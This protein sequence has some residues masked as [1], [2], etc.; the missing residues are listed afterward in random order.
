MGTENHDE[1]TLPWDPARM[2]RRPS[3]GLAFQAAVLL[4]A[5]VSVSAATGFLRW[6]G[7]PE[8]VT[9]AAGGSGPPVVAST[10]PVS[11]EFHDWP[12]KTPDL[13][14][15]LTAQEYGYLQPCGCSKPQLGGLERRWNFL[16]SLKKR[17]WPVLALDLGDI[18]QKSGPQKLLKY[19]V[20]MQALQK[21]GYLAVSIG[22]NELESLF[23]ALGQFALNDEKKQ[24][25]VIC[26][27]LNNLDT[28]YKDMVYPYAVGSA[29]DK[30]P[31]VGVVAAVGPSV[32]Q[33]KHDPQV[34]FI[35]NDKALG[36][37][38]QKMQSLPEGQRPDLYVLLYQGNAAEAKKA[39]EFFPQFRVILCLTREEEP[40]AAPER[41]GDT[42]I[43]GVG[44]KGRHVGVVGLWRTGQ[45]QKPFDLRYQL[46]TLREDLETPAGREA[47]NPIVAMMEEYT[48]EVKKGNYLAQYPRSRHPVQVEFPEA[49]YVGTDKC[50]KCHADAYK[51]WQNSPHHEAYQT[52][53]TAKKPALRQFDGECV[54]CHV[55][56]FDY[57][58]GFVNEV[59]TPHFKDVGCESCHGPGSLHAKGDNSSKL[60]AL[61]NPFRVSPNEDPAAKTKRINSLDASCQKC[62]D[63]DNDVHWDFGKKWPKIEHHEFTKTP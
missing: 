24:P 37:A 7:A 61:M 2:P 52:L 6:L 3:R 62:H 5:F 47:D 41:V 45:E 46:A 4:L 36:G 17:G 48:A 53:V 54:K 40:P 16:Q 63:T 12:Q 49:I 32:G 50:K 34:E 13:V 59:E 14:L 1:R 35:P 20:S 21:M 58:K 30:G 11:N 23:E 25:R 10:K 29:S 55:V 57:Q 31:R 60:L 43:I 19:K 22:H 27:N 39:A 18:P 28:D 38:L 9:P 26:T 15:L 33:M 44:H 42:A 56:G 8:A 51:V